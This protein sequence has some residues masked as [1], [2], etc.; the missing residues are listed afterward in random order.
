MAQL[1]EIYETLQHGRQNDET[2]AGL[3]PV[4]IYRL[5]LYIEAVLEKTQFHFCE[6][7]AAQAAIAFG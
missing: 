5:Y 2:Q 1:V 3:V 4:S 6:K 7:C